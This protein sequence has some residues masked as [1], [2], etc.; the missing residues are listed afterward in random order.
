MLIITLVIVS[1]LFLGFIL[2]STEH[3]NRLNRASVAI[4]CGVTVWI[5]YLIHGGDYL[6]LMH[7]A[8]YQEFLNGSVSTFDTVREF[9]GNNVI[10]KYISEACAVILFLIATNAIVEVMNNNGV[11]D[12]LVKWMRM[13]SS[14]RFLWVVSILTFVISANVDNLTTVVLMLTILRQIVSSH[15]QRTVYACVILIS[16]ALGGTCTVIGD[17]TSLMLWIRGAVTA[18][19]FSAGLVPPALATL[20]VANVLTMNLLVG[21]VEVV[22]A[23]NMYRGDDSLLSRWQKILI[24]VVGIAGLWAIP[25]F[26]SMTNFPPFLGAFCVLACIWII[27]GVFNWQRN[28]SVFLEHKKY[29]RNSEFISMR[30]IL[31]FIGITLSIGVLNE[32]GALAY[33][34]RV[35]SEYVHNVYAYGIIT[36][37][38]SMVV[39]NVPCVMTGMNL[40][41]VSSDAGSDFSVNG[42]YWQ[43]LSY[44]SAMG[45]IALL[46][47]SLAGHSVMQI[48]KLRYSWFCRHMIWRI[49]VAWVVGLFVFWLIH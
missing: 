48:E 44:C 41:E 37:L 22:S 5:L 32:C 47:G 4:F 28:G 7:D 9:L 12:S 40:F 26:K 3:L 45:G 46:F 30:I 14:R 19:E 8:E 25:I 17:M 24:L 13:R 11:F 36:G 20:C 18:S 15:Y 34:G 29:L 43:L 6:R 21:K 35:L 33:I 27:E 1:I 2:M 23:I 39:D 49:I 31:Y 42:V 38:F 16:A 10:S